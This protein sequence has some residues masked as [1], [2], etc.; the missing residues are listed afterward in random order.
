MEDNMNLLFNIENKEKIDNKENK[1]SESDYTKNNYK[2]N[3]KDKGFE[4]RKPQEICKYYLG[5]SCSKGNKCTFSHNLKSVPCKFYHALGYC[6]KGNRCQFG[7]TRLLSEEEIFTFIKSNKPFLDE[8]LLKIG[9]TNMDEFYNKYKQEN[10]ISSNHSNEFIRNEPV[11]CTFFNTNLSN[12]G[13]ASASTNSIKPKEVPEE[14]E[15][16]K[17]IPNK[18]NPFQTALFMSFNK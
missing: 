17:I 8:L 12:L 13:Q 10:G 16:N 5:N 1:E 3:Y 11:N 7:H 2:N 6:D 18:V 14:Q 9:K 15:E 4:R